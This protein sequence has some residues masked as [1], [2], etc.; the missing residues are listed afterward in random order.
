MSEVV[1]VTLAELCR[2]AANRGLALFLPRDNELFLDL[3]GVGEDR[4]EGTKD[5]MDYWEALHKDGIKVED[6]FHT[7]SASGNGIH[8]YILL[9]QAFD[10]RERLI[11]QAALGSDVLKEGLSLLRYMQ[12]SDCPTSLFETPEAAKTVQA[13]L[14]KWR[15]KK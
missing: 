14:E 2:E 7:V 9:N 11:M 10:V 3:D 6:A 12:G 5:S 1:H 8:L 15:H 4:I 13:N